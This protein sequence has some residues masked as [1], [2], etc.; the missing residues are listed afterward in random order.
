MPEAPDAET[1]NTWDAPLCHAAD[2][3]LAKEY[4]KQWREF[5]H[6]FIQAS[7]DYRSG[8]FHREFPEGSYRPPLVKLYS[9]E[10]T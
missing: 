10:G 2:K 9:G 5:V 8:Y 4:K 7:A 6:Q 1:L 3:E